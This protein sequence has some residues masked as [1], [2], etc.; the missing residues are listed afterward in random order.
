MPKVLLVDNGSSYIQKLESLLKGVGLEVVSVDYEQLNESFV[1]GADLIVLSGGHRYTIVDHIEYYR[2]ELELIQLSDKPMIGVCLG[3]E[4]IA[5]CFGSMV[6]YLPE[7]DKGLRTIS[8]LVNDPLF[9]QSSFT[10]YESHQFALVSISKPLIA[11]ASSEHGI[12]IIKHETKPLYGFQF[13]PEVM[14]DSQLGDEL[15]K[16]TIRILLS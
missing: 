3:F 7:K 15:F 5:I 8:V 4:L 13:H 10:V 6:S 1:Q 2:S 16:R 9:T 11:L 14:E 12:E